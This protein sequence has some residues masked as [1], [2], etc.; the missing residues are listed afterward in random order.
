MEVTNRFEGL[1]P[2]K[3]V[4]EELYTE[5]HN[6]AQEEANKTIPEKKKCVM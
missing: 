5:V 4:T 3:F 6:I 2:V 1:D